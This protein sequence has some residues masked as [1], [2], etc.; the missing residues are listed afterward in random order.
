MPPSPQ[1]VVV[2]S[3][4]QDLTFAC[5]EFPRAGETIMARLAGGQGGKGSNQAIACGR[6][7]MKTVFIGAMGRDGFAG[8]VTAFYRR[9]KIGCHLVLKA[10]QSTGTAV[11]LLNREGQNQIVIE[12]GANAALAPADV[13]RS[14]LAKARVVVTQL[15]SNLAT[16]AHVLRVARQAGVTTILNPAPMRT[17]FGPALLRHV[18]I[19]IPNESEFVALVRALPG[20][21][22]RG[23]DERALQAMPREALHG[24]CRQLGVPTLIVTLGRRGCFISER[25]GHHF[26][27]AHRGMRVVD[28]TGAGDAFCGGFA[29]GLVRHKGEVVAAARLGTAV[30]ALSITKPGAAFAMPTRSELQ[31]FL[32]KTGAA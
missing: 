23:F 10:G 12:P 30:A 6:T 5:A 29:A 18:D 17:D 31:R 25:S 21:R 26:I 1:V 3:I 22:R 4:M 16:T 15:E 13:P 11:I 32:R 24:L 28:T 8:Q 2:G 9:E 14:L 27:P 20:I 7:G 19:L